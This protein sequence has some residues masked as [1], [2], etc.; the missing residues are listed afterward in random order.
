MKC[1]TLRTQLTQFSVPFINRRQFVNLIM[2]VSSFFIG[3]LHVVEC[4][5]AKLLLVTCSIALL[6][7]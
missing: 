6:L 7:G 2:S 3:R 4:P 5:G 1:S